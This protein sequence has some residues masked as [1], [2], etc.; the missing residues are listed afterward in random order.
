MAD[1]A[2]LRDY[3]KR[4]IADARDA[5]RKL[6]ELEDKDS[7]PVAVVGMACR[8]PGGVRSPGDLW[9]LV[10]DG[11]DAVA[12]FPVDRGWD[13]DRLFGAD[14]DAVGTSHTR[15]G[16][17][18]YDADLFDAGFF[19]MSPR[20]ALATDPQQRL[21][22][23][24]A[25]EAVET[26]G[27]RPASLRG[28][29]TGVFTGVMYHDYG[30]RPGLATPDIEGYLYSGSAGSIAA[31]RLAYTFGLE[32][33]AVAIDT[34]CSSS[35][36][37]LHLA[38]QALRVGECDLA[39]AGGVTVMSTPT[40]FVEF[41][42]LRG[43]APDGRCRSFAADASGTG[44]SEGIGLLMLERLSD[45]QRNGHRVLAVVRGS[46][47]N[48]DGA[49]NGLTAP[50]GP[51]QE[52]VI[53][54]A[55]GAA[56][57][58]PSDVDVVEAHGTGTVLGDPI[59]AQA[60]LATYGQD[61]ETPLYLGSLKSNIGHAQAAAGV[62][63]VIKMIEAMRHGVLPKTLHAEH[64][65]SHVDWASGSVEL[66]AE[67]RPWPETGRPRRAGVS[68]FGF[69]GTNAHVIVEQGP[70][71]GQGEAEP[72][73]VVLPA[74]PF[75]ASG[76]TEHAARAHAAQLSTVDGTDLDVAYSLAT[77]RSAF[78]WRTA[79]TD[80]VLGE[81]TPVTEGGTA[82]LFTGQGSQRTGMG[83]E[84]ARTFPVFAA[85]LDEVL[86]R[87]DLPLREVI[88]SGEGLERTGWAQP[89]L[90][91]VEVAL[92]RLV[93]SWGVRPDFVAGHSIGEIVAA[94]VAG[95]LSL[96]D[97]ATLVAARGRLM[98]D[99][100]GGGA[101]VAV[102]A[103][104]DE[105]RPLLTPGV[106]IAAV[107]GPE[108]VVLSGG[109]DAVLRVVGVLGARSRRLAVGHAFHSARMD[110]MLVPFAAVAESL[111][112]HEPAVPVVSTLT[113][114]TDGKLTSPDHWVEQVR[115]PVR[116]G[117]AVRTLVRRGVTT[118]VELGPD[119]VLSAMVPAVTDAAVAV[120]LLR[121]ARPEAETA[122]AALGVLHGRG[123]AVDWPA[124][125]RG[126][127]ARRVDLPTYPFQ[128]ERYWLESAPA[129]A[130]ASGHPLLGPATAVAG[131]GRVLF[132]S[133]I[134]ARSW[135]A[136]HLAVPPAAFVEMAIHAGDQVGTPVLAE[137]DTDRPL[138][139][140]AQVQVSVDAPA[141][142]G[143]RTF[144]VYARPDDDAAW[145]AHATG[146]LAARGGDEPVIT[147]DGTPVR[148]PEAITGEAAAYGLHPA[149]LDLAVPT[150]ATGATV[151]VPGSWR[152]VRLHAAHAEAVEVRVRQVADD[153]VTLVLT[154]AAGRPV[155]TAEAVG[156]RDI[157]VERF[158]AGSP[159]RT[160]TWTHVP[161]EP[162]TGGEV[163]HLE[164]GTGDPVAAAHAAVLR[165]LE[166]VR[167][168][169]EPLVVVTAGG[170][171]VADE[172][173]DLAAAAAWGLLRSAQSELPEG[174]LVLVD[175]DGDVVLSGEPQVAVR[176]GRVF[177]PRLT[178]VEPVE[179]VTG[180]VA[181][182]GTALVTGGLGVLVARH[183]VSVHG[184]R[185]VVLV[186]VGAA[187]SD[188]WNAETVHATW[189]ELAEV[190]AEHR[191]TAVVH[192][193]GVPDDGPL[194][195]ITPER[196]AAALKPNVDDAWRLHELLPDAGLFVVFSST[197]GVLGAPGRAGFAA[198]ASFAD[199]L[200]R[201]RAARGL[202]AVSIAFGPREGA[203]GFPPVADGELLGLLDA[204]VDAG[205]PVVVAAPVDVVAL[206]AADRAPVPLRG[207]VAPRRREA[208][209][210]RAGTLAARLAGLAGDER[211][212][213]VLDLVRR[214]VAAVLG[215]QDPAAIGEHRPF[216]D[217]GFD[218]LTSVELRNRLTTATG[219][220]LQ[221][222]LV[223]DHP[224]PA[225]L[226]G[227][228]L[229]V[230]APEAAEPV[231]SGLDRL[232]ALL[233][234]VARED[235]RR[236]EITRRLRTILSRWTSEWGRPPADA[237]SIE[238][239][240]ASAGELFDFIDNELGRGADRSA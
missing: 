30:S 114:E 236:G 28:S 66:L 220:A 218:S 190:V 35:L 187:D 181:W 20:E 44:W 37:S 34:A 52:R 1:E 136:D 239:E 75:L 63:G 27:V 94:H 195:D 213:A 153:T 15:E 212:A 122:A 51:S 53:R 116:F 135:L 58:G 207:V 62:G 38:A 79:G 144:T 70:E 198:A 8:Y 154:D 197:A 163:V 86:A 120:P 115:R 99:L 219:V 146:V 161:A 176:G 229:G 125:F 223:F 209:D 80:R 199:A 131:S 21:L 215:Q 54:A 172:D 126:A 240:S 201:H 225:E 39:L 89:A 189:G 25:W 160:L 90:F 26:A 226:T 98:Q 73:S 49:S 168:R 170:V 96:E 57:L 40:A 67:A 3:L 210:E 155:L 164:I 188:T 175:T 91:A 106:D 150:T 224:T 12:G 234:G 112:Y 205:H 29:R 211:R 216:R 48:Q 139:L 50:N 65:T 183:L 130:R 194:A 147:A 107:N 138:T 81:P 10:D 76:K 60:L 238:L 87:F 83:L 174:R 142:D 123:V 84:L 134:E 145:T 137:L 203:V 55:L 45:A 158:A 235:D 41:S 46:A 127:G 103:T 32:G 33:P 178:A 6:R 56:G 17:F 148:L 167:E 24:T 42:R 68:S 119:A 233:D 159:L 165:A 9:R 69:G 104:E 171:A 179:P 156:F 173:V 59:E 162:A 196:L 117:D 100:P 230:L 18:L 124:F 88:A 61:R 121:R 191:P 231:L 129:A 143:R 221:A 208:G 92:F 204:A 47:V 71:P 184:V 72:V 113:G 141:P 202:P 166:L 93:E 74:V 2:K 232:E 128:H 102:R 152:G 105:V 222:T 19:G 11:V 186:D 140:P 23:E 108:S 182:G 97:A 118:L 85:A 149:L 77:G 5:R 31:G 110:P 217:L 16:G 133:T 109:E 22:L 132:T 14:P 185:K 227:H 169:S 177:A 7:E 101:M 206:R 95:V 82:F 151:R 4:A 111:T 13:L 192:T 228:V 64:P 36:V 214:E 78:G 157:P 180:E 43:L 200:A 237:P 193:G